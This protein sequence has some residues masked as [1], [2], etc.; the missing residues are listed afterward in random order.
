[1]EEE[2][3]VDQYQSDSNDENLNLDEVSDDDAALRMGWI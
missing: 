3:L 1:M 2:Q